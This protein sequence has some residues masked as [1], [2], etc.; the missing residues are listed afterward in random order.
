MEKDIIIREK[1]A[2]FITSNSSTEIDFKI[3]E[4]KL[5]MTYYRC[6]LFET[7]TKF[8]VLDE[9]LSLKYNHSPIESIKTRI[10]SP[11]SIRGKIERLGLDFNLSEVEKNINDIAGIRIICSYI[12]DIYMLADCLLSQDDVLL[13]QRKD[14]IAKPKPNGYRSLH[15]IIKIPIF[16]SDEKRYV[17]VE[18]QLRTIAMESWANLE[19]GL[20][21]KNELTYDASTKISETLYQCALLSAELDEK[22]QFARNLVS[23]DKTDKRR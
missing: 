5:L 6:A 19:H 20:R 4:A 23:T 17:K 1:F 13:V 2:E 16:L 3:R 10:K 9:Q 7:E 11:E 8:R 22:M 12:D 14:Y 21:Y 15:L 18:V